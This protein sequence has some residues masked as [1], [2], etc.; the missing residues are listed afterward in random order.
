MAKA[1]TQKDVNEIVDK[2]SAQMD[3]MEQRVLLLEVKLLIAKVEAGRT[4]F[5]KREL[6]LLAAIGLSVQNS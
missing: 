6:E 3:E 2:V 5:T 4:T 1:I